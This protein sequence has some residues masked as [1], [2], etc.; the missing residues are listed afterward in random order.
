MNHHGAGIEDLISP[1]KQRME[2][3]EEENRALKAHLAQARQELAELKRGVGITVY[4]AGKAVQTGLN[5]N[6]DVLPNGAASAGP[7]NPQRAF[8]T[9]NLGNGR[10]LADN[11]NQGAPNQGYFP[12]QRPNG[13]IAPDATPDQPG[14]SGPRSPNYD[15]FFLD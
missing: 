11:Q 2:L 5:P 14:R 9:P 15:N 10:P 4:V 6:P 1:L 8:A 3:L 12:P 7:P 13:N